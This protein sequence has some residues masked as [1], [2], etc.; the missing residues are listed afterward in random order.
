MPELTLRDVMTREFVGVSESDAVIG[1][2]RLMREEGV[3]NAIVLRGQEPVGTI[4]AGDVLDLL[5]AG[6]DVDATQVRDVMDEDVTTL[7]PE[8]PIGDAASALA[9]GDGD[10]ILVGDQQE[11]LGVIRPEDI[12]QFAWDRT[13]TG[14]QAVGVGGETQTRSTEQPSEG[15]SNQSICE[16]CGTLS[17]DLVNVNGQLLCPDCRSV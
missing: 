15:Y 12:A 14:E 5:V 7:D 16:A 2:V 13:E 3:R 17:R 11:L 8:D 10:Q 6:R 1:A 4:G 9:T